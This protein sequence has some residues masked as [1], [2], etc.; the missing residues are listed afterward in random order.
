MNI[1]RKITKFLAVGLIGMT[2]FVSL[3]AGTSH[4]APQVEW[5]TDQVVSG[6]VVDALTFKPLGDKRIVVYSYATRTYEVTRTDRYG[7]FV[8]S[9]LTGDEFAVAM[10]G[11][12]VHCSGI[13]LPNFDETSALDYSFTLNDWSTFSAGHL[14]LMGAHRVGSSSCGGNPGVNPFF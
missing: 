14:G 5:P 8:V 9:D 7:K 10:V 11:D 3:G 13:A 6:R 12:R 4:A 2:A 1:T